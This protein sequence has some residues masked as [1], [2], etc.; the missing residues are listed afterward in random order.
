M[1]GYQSAL[2]VM[3]RRQSSTRNAIQR[4]NWSLVKYSRVLLDAQAQ[5]QAAGSGLG[6]AVAAGLGAESWRSLRNREAR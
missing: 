4:L 1:V 5:V 2:R 6:L 3:L